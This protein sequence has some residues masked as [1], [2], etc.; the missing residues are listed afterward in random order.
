MPQEPIT[1]LQDKRIVLGVTGSIAAYKAV[2]LASKL[3]QAGALVDV[4]MTE[5]AEKFVTSLTFQA[6][7]GRPVYDNLWQASGNS[8]LPTHIAHVGLGEG[9]DLL[10]VA[11]ATANTLAKLAQGMADDLL[12]VTT[13]AAR[14]PLV[15]APAMDGGMYQHPATRT[16]VQ[17]L[18]ARG[19]YLIEPEEGRFA[20]GLVGKGRLPETPT[21]MGHIRRALAQ[22]GALKGRKVVITAGGTREPIDPVRYI[23]NRSSGKQGYALAQAAADA[24]ANVVL[25]STV[26]DLPL[27]VGANHVPVNSAE[28]M[29]NAVLEAVKDADALVMAAAVADFRPETV[30]DQKIKKKDGS[31]D[32]PTLVLARTADIL[33]SVKEQRARTGFPRVA[34]GFAAES[35]DLVNYARSKLE[36]KGLD[37]L[38][39][40][41]IT[42]RDA[43]FEVD[44]NRVIILDAEGG[45]TPLD[46]TSKTRVAEV[47][48]ERVGALLAE[49]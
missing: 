24:G 47:I 42:A 1:L 31:N 20:S 2:D 49:R 15:I 30:A 18:M 13:L 8:S 33:L 38:V 16:N 4:I 3:T 35:Q 17:T 9:A 34:V 48:V 10:L 25:I 12:T 29:L 36:R 41:D 19:A 44:N 26:R 39:A 7:T 37:M 22:D 23:T 40:N 14:C 21:L 6:V 5:A 45:Q 28:E 46:L 27:P 11:P 43:G 32:A